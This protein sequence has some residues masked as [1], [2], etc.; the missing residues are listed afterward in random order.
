MST[1]KLPAIRKK[2][3]NQIHNQDKN[4]LMEKITRIKELTDKGIKRAIINMLNM[5]KD[6]KENRNMMRAKMKDIF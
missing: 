4:H 3:E 2:Q 1:Q 6:L 5:F